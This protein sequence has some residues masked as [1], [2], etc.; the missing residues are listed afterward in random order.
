MRFDYK[1]YVFE[2]NVEGSK[3]AS[4]YLRALDMLGE[5]LALSQGPFSAIHRI[6]DEISIE[7]IG[8][9]YEY[10]REQQKLG[11]IFQTDHAPS[12]WKNKYYSAALKSYR[13]FLVEFHYEEKLLAT[14]QNDDFRPE[15][16]EFEIPDEKFL[17]PSSSIVA[18]EDAV[19]ET[20]VRVGQ[21][22]FRKKI[23]A[24]YEN[25]CCITG[26][27]IPALNVASH[28]VRWSELER[29]RL[30]PG[31]GLC[32]SGTYDLAFDKHLFSLDEDYRIIL[33]SE[34]REHS[35]RE[36]VKDYFLSIEG[37]RIGLPKQ[38]PPKQEFLA[39]HRKQM[40]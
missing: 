28:I 39:K 37:K 7:K 17:L 38:F 12:Y 18:G 30:D 8:D 23:L 1:R 24:V 22:V 20:K 21:T 19:K 25:E 14:Y 34:I 31:N 9:L 15:E 27:N 33:S 40:G 32:L 35:T 6:W 5:I 10:I 16:F 29:S 36:V 26:L 3:K 4:S 13:S 11:T 2:T